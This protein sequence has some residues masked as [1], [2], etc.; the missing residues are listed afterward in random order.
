MGVE[1]TGSLA[2]AGFAAGERGQHGRAIFW[3]PPTRSSALNQ[4]ERHFNV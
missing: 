2:V 1:L 4:K 3:R